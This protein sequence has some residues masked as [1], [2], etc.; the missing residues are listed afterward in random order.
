MQGF[1]FQRLKKLKKFNRLNPLFTYSNTQI[2]DL[3][4][5]QTQNAERKRERVCV[6]SVCGL[7]LSVCDC[8]R[9]GKGVKGIFGISRKKG[10][11]P[12]G[13]CLFKKLK[14]VTEIKNKNNYYIYSKFSGSLSV[15]IR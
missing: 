8:E 5:I 6:F 11:G 1:A 14:S 7:Y 2:W 3:N 12:R 13:L 9:E 4:R 15:Y 10:A